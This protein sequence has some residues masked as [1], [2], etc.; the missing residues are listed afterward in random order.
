MESEIEKAIKYLAEQIAG[1][2]TGSEAMHFSQAALNLAHVKQVL[3]QT[4]NK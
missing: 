3:V 1:S 4:K 2:V